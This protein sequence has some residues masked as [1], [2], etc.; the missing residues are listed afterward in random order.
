MEIMS[1]SIFHTLKLDNN[2]LVG[3]PTE[4]GNL[5]SLSQR[6]VVKNQQKLETYFVFL[7]SLAL[8]MTMTVG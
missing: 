1:L 7:N 5:L 8:A 3:H 6:T 2:Q 4:V